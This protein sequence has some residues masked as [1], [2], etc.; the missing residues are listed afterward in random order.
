M[1]GTQDLAFGQGPP[2]P[3]R[4][5]ALGGTPSV[6]PDVPISVIFFVLY[7]IFGVVHIVIFKK[8]KQRG[9]K[10]VFN[11]AILGLC[12]IRLITMTLRIAWACYPGNTGLAMAANIFVYVGTI[13]LYMANWFFVQRIVRA[14]HARLGWSTPYRV[15][16]RAALVCL[17][18]TLIILIVSQVSRNFTLNEER[19]DTFRALFLASQTYFAIFCFAPVILIATSLIIPRMEV[20]KF[21]AG[22][23]RVNIAVL[24]IAVMILL[25][26]QIFR[27]VLAWIPQTALLDLSGTNTLPWYLSKA[28]FY[29]FNFVTEMAVVI[30]YA[31]TRVDLRFHIP[32]GARRPGDYSG[33]RVD[34]NR[35]ESAKGLAESGDTACPPMIHQSD[36]SQTLHQYQ[37]SVFEEAKTLAD[38]LRYPSSILE[39][40]QKTGSWKI[41]RQSSGSSSTHTS[42]SYAPSS[43]TT[44]NDRRTIGE[45]IPPVPEIPA[46]WPLPDAAPPR[47]SG[48]VLEHQNP[49]SRRGTPKDTS[50]VGSPELNDVDIGNA[51]TD[52]LATLEMNSEEKTAMSPKPPKTLPPRFSCEFPVSPVSPLQTHNPTL[53]IIDDTLPT[54]TRSRRNTYPLTDTPPQ[55][56]N[57]STRASLSAA[58]E[59]SASGT[60]ARKSSSRYSDDTE[61][62][63]AGEKDMVDEE[64][65]RFSYEAAS[66]DRNGE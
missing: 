24:L 7:L 18:V 29:I 47:G 22:R 45:D 38:S 8:N 2:Y 43:R 44:L 3:P 11:G 23:L 17:I 36:S 35:P 12:K 26:G 30:I 64:F 40:D 66:S 59:V 6:E 49:T 48:A 57:V 39:V 10:F 19:L 61:S 62:S 54:C 37:S 52:A 51:V 14:Q 5:V 28:C 31:V 63:V 58:S 41:R 34:S 55:H 15:F 4:E 60:V 1:S 65:G 50:E 46:E 42:I 33:R 21:G 13:I 53:P 9:H 27:C 32:N 16:H 20:E 56:E 25:T